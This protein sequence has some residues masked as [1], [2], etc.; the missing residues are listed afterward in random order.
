MVKKLDFVS[1]VNSTEEAERMVSYLVYRYKLGY[2]SLVLIIGARGTGKSSVSF[3]LDELINQA[4]NPIR[5]KEGIE[6][7]KFGKMEDSHLGFMKFVRDGQDGDTCKL[8]E[9][10]VLYPSR[11]A[12]SDDSVG[13]SKVLDIIRKKR[14]IIFAN[15]PMALST[16]KNIRASSCALIKTF[17]IIK[18]EKAVISTFFK[19]QTDYMTGKTYTHKFTRNGRKIDFMHTKMPNQDNWN[20]YEADKD[21]FID[22]QVSKL[23]QKAK[24]KQEKELNELGFGKPQRKPLTDKQEAVMKLLANNTLKETAKILEVGE[25]NVTKHKSASIKKGYTLKEFE[26]RDENE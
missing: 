24:L 14:L 13:V 12:M 21:S 23:V 15:T 20:E 25:V 10:G 5:K 3:R 7:R 18:S 22:D 4:L 16:D 26:K 2:S 6:E 19:L 9:I 1:L 17:K 11:R 8:E